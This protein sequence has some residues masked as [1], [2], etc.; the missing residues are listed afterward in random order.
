MEVFKFFDLE[1]FRNQ[2]EFYR[3]GGL[4]SSDRT[5]PADRHGLGGFRSLFEFETVE[6]RRRILEIDG[7]LL[8]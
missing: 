1:T 2:L 5:Q 6:E 3:I 7:N 8:N 4:A